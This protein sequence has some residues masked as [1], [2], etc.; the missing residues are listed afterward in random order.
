MPSTQITAEDVADWNSLEEIADCF[1]SKK[2]L[3]RRE[4]LSD[5]DDELVLE[6][7]DG[8]FMVLIESEPSKSAS[9]YQSRTN[10]RRRT[11]F[12]ATSGYQSFTFTTRKRSFDEH[13]AIK[14]QQF[15]FEKDEIV[16]GSGKKFSKLEKINELEYGR[17]TSYTIP[18]RLLTSST[19]SSKNYV[20]T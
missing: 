19:R 14:F 1:E 13:G 16:S 5:R 10:A 7:D 6:I 18:E 2:E 17:Y 11:N 3:K 15:S 12:V 4:G 9:D 20:P 8:E